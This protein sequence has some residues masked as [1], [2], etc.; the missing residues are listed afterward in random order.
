MNQRVNF[1]ISGGGKVAKYY[2]AASYTKD[3]GV[4]KMDNQNNFNSGIDLQK[5]NVRS[6]ININLTPTTEAS[7]RFQGSFDDYRGPVDGGDAL[8]KK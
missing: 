1:N 7:I 8:F 4:I 6:N 5:F 2:I 3:N